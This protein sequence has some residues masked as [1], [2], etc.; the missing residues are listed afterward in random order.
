MAEYEWLNGRRHSSG[1]DKK[2]VCPD[3]VTDAGYKYNASFAYKAYREGL[4]KF[5]DDNSFCSVHTRIKEVTHFRTNKLWQVY[6]VCDVC[7]VDGS[8]E[9]VEVCHNCNKNKREWV[10]LVEPSDTF[11][12]RWPKFYEPQ[13]FFVQEGPLPTKSEIEAIRQEREAMEAAYAEEDRCPECGR[14]CDC[15]D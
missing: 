5:Y 12:A 8:T 1:A 6:F 13:I 11:K 2:H 7:G 14:A 10:R 3:C 4:M 15:N 9:Q